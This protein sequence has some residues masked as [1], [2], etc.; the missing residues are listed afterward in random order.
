LGTVDAVAVQALAP[1]LGVAVG[2]PQREPPDLDA[3]HGFEQ[4]LQEG[5]A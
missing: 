3:P 5:G 1:G 4:V 2:K